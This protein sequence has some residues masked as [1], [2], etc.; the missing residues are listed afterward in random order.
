MPINLIMFALIVSDV[1]YTMRRLEVDS[2]IAHHLDMDLT[3][4]TIDLKCENLSHLVIQSD[5]CINLNQLENLSCSLKSLKLTVNPYICDLG[6]IGKFRNLRTLSLSN[7]S[8][9]SDI[10]GDYEA[11][12]FIG[13]FSLSKLEALTLQ[14]FQALRMIAVGASSGKLRNLKKIALRRTMDYSLDDVKIIASRLPRLQYFEIDDT[15]DI[16]SEIEE[17]FSSVSP[18]FDKILFTSLPL[19][20]TWTDTVQLT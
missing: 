17:I 19:L 13:I 14:G 6:L 12:I 8:S 20:D 2:V 3:L 11:A 10:N 18:M 1:G 15:Y 5:K 7:V 9:I 4:S 16:V